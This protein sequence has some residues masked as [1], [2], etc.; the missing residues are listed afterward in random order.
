MAMRPLVTSYRQ[1]FALY[2]GRWHRAGVLLSVALVVLY[3]L[4]AD[5]YWLSIGNKALITIVG[6]SAL[7]ILTGFAGQIS[8]GHAAF[9]AVGAYTSAILAGR[10]GLPFWLLLPLSG[11]AAGFVGLLVGPFALRLKGVYLAIVTLGLIYLVNHIL[12]ALPNLTGGSSGLAVPMHIWF[13]PDAIAGGPGDFTRKLELGPFEMGFELKLY[14]LY[15]PL[16][17]AVIYFTKN[18]QRSNPGR[19]MMAV[20]DQDLAAQAMGVHLARTKILAMFL[21]SYIAGV[22]GSMF[23]FKQQFITIDPPFNLVFS[24][25]YIAIIVLGG[26]GTVFGA[27]AGALAFVY[28]SPLA[29]HIG[30]YIPY[31][32][33]L[34]NAEQSVLLFSLLVGAILLYEPLGIFGLWLKVK[35]YFL[36]WPFRR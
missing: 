27:V 10:F 9:F 2:P 22:G 11:F 14:M 24:I 20:R 17:A 13:A 21:S 28:L 1:D 8:L 7:M 36:A 35:R 3:P 6:A 18:L 15:L 32:N 16:T 23:A 31:I 12:F 30:R 33:Q 19:A 34:T 29:E 5:D 4:L 26:V 25:E